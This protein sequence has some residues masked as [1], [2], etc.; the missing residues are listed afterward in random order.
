MGGPAL[1]RHLDRLERE[2]TVE[3]TRDAS[4]RRITRVTLTDAGRAHLADLVEVIEQ[5][6]ARLRHVITPEEADVLQRALQKLFEFAL[7]ESHDPAPPAALAPPPT[8]DPHPR[9]RR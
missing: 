1:V 6:D 5:V 9:S 3:R 7:R 2:G 8:T 4:D